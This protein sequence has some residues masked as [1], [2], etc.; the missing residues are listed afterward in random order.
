[1]ALAIAAACG[2][3]T[4][5]PGV[6]SGEPVDD[7][8]PGAP[9]A[10]PPDLPRHE[11]GPYKAYLGTLHDH[12]YGV[13]AG[14]DGGLRNDAP[15]EPGVTG[16][17]EWRAFRENN[18]PYY[19]GGDAASAYL[20]AKEASLDFFALTPHNHLID[21]E[22][23]GAVLAAARDAE[24]IVALVGQ[25]WSSVNSGNHATVMN[26]ENRVTVPNGQYDALIDEWIPGYVANHPDAQTTFGARP[27]MILAHPA[28]TS[29]DYTEADKQLYEYGIDDYGS[30][31]AWAAA[32]NTQVRLVELQSGD[33]GDENG[34]PRALEILND[35]VKVGFSVGPDNH[36]Q[37]WGTRTDGR[38]GA[39]APRW[40]KEGVS[41]A[42]HARRTYATE[43]KDLGA[44]LAVLDGPGGATVGWMGETVARP[45][46]SL[47]LEIGLEDPSQPGETYRIEVLV[48]DEIGGPQAFLVSVPGL[49]SSVGEGTREISLPA[50][51][52]GGYVLVHVTQQGDGDDLWFSPIW[53]E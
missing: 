12:H 19:V 47:V 18:P 24:G 51:P 23:Y 53:M 37:R 17:P 15:D 22:E 4:G 52:S 35:G 29:W 2:G 46:G 20:A 45:S 48:D 11:A 41:E 1:M 36:R 39:L 3:G 49:P 10:E 8:S 14:D 5:T 42:L 26:V 25:E 38:I 7:A 40:S 30:V 28:L 31:A 6:D 16:S 32:L 50:P 34:L 9:D 44:H 13:N 33:E 27:F 21:N 43:D